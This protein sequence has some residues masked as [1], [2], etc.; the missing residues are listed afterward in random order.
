MSFP[1]VHAQTD[2]KKLHLSTIWGPALTNVDK[3]MYGVEIPELEVGDA[4]LWKGWSPACWL[5]CIAILLGLICCS[6][7][8]SMVN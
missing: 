1:F 4:I 3:I 7:K 8:C 2:G 6:D 5:A